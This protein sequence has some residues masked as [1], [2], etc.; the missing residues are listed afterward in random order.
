M[1]S[2]EET[3][4]RGFSSSFHRAR[5]TETEKSETT[6][7]TEKSETTETT[8]SER[9][10]SRART[11]TRTSSTREVQSDARSSGFPRA[12][13]SA[14]ARR[15]TGL[16]IEDAA[17]AAAAR[18][19]RRRRRDA[20]RA[21]SEREVEVGRRTFELGDGCEHEMAIGADAVT[22]WSDGATRATYSCEETPAD[23]TWCA[24][25]RGDDV[26]ARGREKA[27]SSDG[28]FL[29]ATHRDSFSL[30]GLTGETRRMPLGFEAASASATSEGLL[31]VSRRGGVYIVAHALDAPTRVDGL[32]DAADARVVWSDARRPLV[33]TYVP[34]RRTHELWTLSLVP[35]GSETEFSD[36]APE[37]TTR[38]DL[39]WTENARHDFAWDSASYSV[40]HDDDGRETFLVSDNASRRVWALYVGDAPVDGC[41][42]REVMEGTSAIGVSATRA[43][44]G[45]LDTLA[46]GVDGTLELRVGASTLC[47]LDVLTSEGASLMGDVRALTD[48]VGSCVTVH[49]STCDS[50]PRIRVPGSLATPHARA[51]YAVLRETCPRG[52]FLEISRLLYASECVGVEDAVNE[53]SHL[54]Q[55]LKTWSGIYAKPDSHELS[56]WEYAQ[57]ILHGSV[58]LEVVESSAGGHDDNVNAARVEVVLAAVHTVYEAAKV[59][60][61][62]RGMLKPLRVFAQTLAEIIASEE[63]LD[64]YARDSGSSVSPLCGSARTECVPDIMR[65]IEGMFAG[66][67]NF[68]TLIPSLVLAGLEDRASVNADTF[69]GDVLVRARRV[70]KICHACTVEV[71]GWPSSKGTIAFTMAEMGFTL[72]DLERLPPGLALPFQGILRCCTDMPS[73]GLPAEA[74][75]L[76]GRKDLALMYDDAELARLSS[77]RRPADAPKKTI[78]ETPVA[79]GLEHLEQFVGPLRF[80]RDYRIREVRSILGTATPVP[81]TI[82]DGDGAGGDAEQ[83]SQQQ[84]KLWLLAS[85][86]AAMPVGRGACTLGTVVVKPTEALQIPTLCLAGCLPAQQYAVVNLDHNAADAPKAFVDWPEFHNGAASGLSL[87]S[88]DTD[89]LTRAWIVFNR[90]KV[91]T[92]SHAG[93]LLALGLNGHLS[94][95]TATDLYRYLAQEHEATTIGTLLGVAASKIGTGDSATSRMCFLHLPTRHPLSFPEIELPSLVQSCALLSVGLLYQGTAQRLIVETLLSELGKSPEGSVITGRESYALSAGFALGLVTLGRGH[96]ASGLSDLH[97]AERLRHFTVGG[98][99]RRIPPPGGMPASSVARKSPNA[100]VTWQDTFPTDDDWMY[101]PNNAEPPTPS[102]DG[103]ILEGSMVNVDLTAPGAIVALGLM[104][105]KTNDAS[106]SAHLQVPSTHYGLDDARPDYVMLRVVARSLIMWDTV[107]SSASWVE[108]LLPPLLRDAMD[109]RSPAA[110]ESLNDSSWVGE[111]DREAIA[112]TYVYVLAGACMSIGLR[113]AGSGNA[114]AS[115]TLRHYAFKFVEWKK[116][117]GQDG[118]ETLVTKSALETCIGVVAMS[119]SCVMAGT[120]DLPTL[121]LLRHLRLRLEKNASSDAGL[122]Y[123]A[124]VAIGLANGFLFLGGGAQTFSTDNESIAALL[125]AMFP[126]FSEN[127]NDNRW[128][129]QAYRHLYALAARE[130]L[131]DTVDANTLEPVST[132][133][134]ITAVTPRGKE[135]STQLVTP[136]LLPDPAT[137]SRV[138]IISPRYWSLDLN[139]ARVGEKAKETLYALR[140]LPVQRRTAS[141]SYEM[142]RTGAKSQLATALHAAGARAALKPPSIESSVDENSAPLANATA[143]RAGRDAVDVFASDATLLAFAKHMCDGSSDRAGYTAAALR[144][145]MGREV[146]KSLRSYV[147]MYASCEAL[148]RS[149]E[150]SE[151][152]VVAAALAISDLRLLD[153]FHGLL[154]RSNVDV[155]AIDEVLPMPMLLASSFRKNILLSLDAEYG[156]RRNAALAMYLRGEGYDA[157][158]DAHGGFGCYLRLLGVPDPKSLRAAIESGLNQSGVNDLSAAALRSCLP[159]AEPSTILH[160]IE[161]CLQH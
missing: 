9:T 142:D 154:K 82:D 17:A 124:H 156:N 48:C 131:L 51:L 111:A 64:H 7:T 87:R 160:V 57:R 27:T 161:A 55:I 121:R 104:Y 20:R 60:L 52:D 4:G 110:Q 6:E 61:L 98:V 78:Q 8:T 106:V 91:P 122:T 83:G 90:P 146:P 109:R 46:V 97:I 151:K 129:C 75:A 76:I 137:L 50:C 158:S 39:V 117:A 157:A 26:D 37:F 42:T 66:T 34:S 70:I 100:G 22:W 85:R 95:L 113:Y 19:E 63:H 116:T 74:Y 30:F 1:T 134:E 53:W 69:G 127:P 89:K 80:P 159:D 140:S 35:A 139:F 72:D 73:S 11:T 99:V 120:G 128:Y 18:D 79:D 138:R 153:A 141:L 135:V 40:A 38:A 149:I 103:L 54:V 58:S 65:A 12:H 126:Q 77:Q 45:M 28:W 101:D 56:D 144:E 31:F 108:G 152:G 155:D 32:S 102:A 107:D 10:R 118:K 29:C 148:T 123:G 96:T 67:P 147:D 93:V 43:S 13:G 130:R 143:A 21:R 41:R 71:G 114:E 92:F 25:R 15:L 68:H 14:V 115:A 136:C 150:K 5:S 86:T 47:K 84:A 23:A 16:T 59:D 81:I 2:R 24:F 33:L 44:E 145:C 133:I 62:H 125:I 36:A 49:A 105:L 88:E 94:S 119:L 3:T 132:P 112:Q